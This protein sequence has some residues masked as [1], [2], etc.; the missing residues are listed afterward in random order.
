[1]ADPEAV[2]ADI[3]RRIAAAQQQHARAQMQREA[4]ERDAAAAFTKVQAFGVSTV[5]EAHAK[6][7]E[8]TAARDE[9]VADAV[10]LLE[11]IGF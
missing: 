1:M 6:H 3:R 5:E 8:L 10:K 7:V 2:V 11:D 9:A 4:A